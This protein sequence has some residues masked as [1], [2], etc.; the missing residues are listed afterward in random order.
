[1]GLSDICKVSLLSK[2]SSDKFII[3]DKLS[4]TSNDLLLETN[5]GLPETFKCESNEPF[6]RL[7]VLQLGDFF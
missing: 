1:M 5:S 7:S 6:A 3:I 4:M 2:L